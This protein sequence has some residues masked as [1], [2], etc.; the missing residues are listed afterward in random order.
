MC[1]N[2]GRYPVKQGGK[3]YEKDSNSTYINEYIF[4][5]SMLFGDLPG[6]WKSAAC[7]DDGISGNAG[8]QEQ[9]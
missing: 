1:L 8:W 2:K 6:K 9:Q 3:R 5:C 4:C 7:V